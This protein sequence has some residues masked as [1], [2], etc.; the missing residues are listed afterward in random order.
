MPWNETDWVGAAVDTAAAALATYGQQKTNEENREIAREQM[1]FQ[2]RMSNTAVQRSIEDYRK[3]GLNPALAY[4]RSA[5]S[6]GGATATMGNVGGAAAAGISS[7]RQAQIA[8]AQLQLQ[9]QATEANVELTRSQAAKARVETANAIQLG[10]QLTLTNRGLTA[11][12]PYEIRKNAA[13]A[14]L[15]EREAELTRLQIPAARANAKWAGKAGMAL[16][17]ISTARDAAR[18][19]RPF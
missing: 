18:I 16:P 11:T 5:S 17:I 10:D 19:L 2:E 9:A 4:E 12:Q 6:P 8:R 13:D 7:A 3:A 15:R 14:L 1:A